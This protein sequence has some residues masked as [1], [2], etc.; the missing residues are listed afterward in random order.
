[1]EESRKPRNL[2][3]TSNPNIYL[4]FSVSFE[5]LPIT[6]T[7]RYSWYHHTRKCSKPLTKPLV[8]V[9]WW[10]WFLFILDVG[11]LCCFTCDIV[12]NSKFVPIKHKVY[13][14]IWRSIKQWSIIFKI[15]DICIIISRQLLGQFFSLLV[16]GQ[17]QYREK[18]GESKNVSIRENCSKIVL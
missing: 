5:R 3:F 2:D 10:L 9:S 14:L 7:W 18:D 13:D 12:I 17:K 1:M 8:F 11:L 4:G 15:N 16:L 6:E